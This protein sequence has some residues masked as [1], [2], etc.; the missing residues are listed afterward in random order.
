[1]M[2]SDPVGEMDEGGGPPPVVLVVDDDPTSRL[3]AGAALKDQMR[4]VEAENGLVALAAL[5]REHVDIA[6]LDLDMPVMDGF[7]VIERARARP[8][9]RHLPIIVVT[10]RE[11]VV[12]IERAFALG[13]TSFLCKPINWNVFRHQVGYVLNV[14]QAERKL[15]AANKRLERLAALRARCIAALAREIESPGAGGES[16][17]PRR[18]L[19]RIARASDLLTGAADMSPQVVSAYDIA[20]AA[21]RAV[22]AADG[23]GAAER[24]E[25]YAADRLDLVCDADLVVEA[26]AEIL[27][28]ALAASPPHEKVRLGIVDAPPDQVRFEIEDRGPGIPEYLLDSGFDDLASAHPTGAAASRPGLGIVLAKAIVERHGGHFGIM[29]EPGRGTEVFLSFP[30]AERSRSQPAINR[31]AQIAS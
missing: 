15:R 5:E 22:A 28:N 23:H 7:G 20:T 13:A 1:M 24:I 17:R 31:A 29:S 6:V 21:V 4:V 16:E 9:T 12:S 25:T 14:A 30:S 19:S 18:L 3:L 26:L 27:R 10:G 8:E 2:L 11:D